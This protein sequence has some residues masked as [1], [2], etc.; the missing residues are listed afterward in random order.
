MA[1]AEFVQVARPNPSHGT[2]SATL[3]S[4]DNALNFIR[5]VLASLV[6]VGHAPPSWVSRRSP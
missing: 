4:R 5:L 2:L 1:P 3:E 6:I